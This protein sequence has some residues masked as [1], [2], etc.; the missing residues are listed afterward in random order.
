[1]FV[2]YLIVEGEKALVD[3][4]LMPYIVVPLLKWF[5]GLPIPSYLRNPLPDRFL[6]RLISPYIT[7]CGFKKE[8]IETT[9]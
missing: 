1:M 8:E 2:T 4:F 3:P 7:C 5:E 6:S 9:A